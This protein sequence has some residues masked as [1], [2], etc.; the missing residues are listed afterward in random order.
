[1]PEQDLGVINQ[2]EESEHGCTVSQWF[3]L[4]QG[5]QWV[6]GSASGKHA[7]QVVQ[8]EGTLFL[9]E[10]LFAEPTWV[11][12]TSERANTL[13]AYRDGRWEPFVKF[14]RVH[15]GWM[16]GHEACAGFY[17]HPTEDTEPIA[18]PAGV[19][20]DV[21]RVAYEQVSDPLALCAPPAFIEL[22]FANG[23]GVVSIKNGHNEVMPLVSARVGGKYYP[24]E[25]IVEGNV[26]TDAAKY[27][28][29][30]NTIR[31]IREPCPS[32]EKTAV[33]KA[34]FVVKNQGKDAVE[35]EFS[36]GCQF[37][38]RIKNDEGVIVKR[39]ADEMACLQSLTSLRL[40][41]G[42]EKV[43]EARLELRDRDGQ[44]LDGEF[45]LEAQLT[46]MNNDVKVPSAVSKFEVSYP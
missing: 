34:A 8:G 5:N 17:A 40:E 1:L 19:F 44:Q 7:V 6:F 45:G 29:L 11:S 4:E 31:C 32:N 16:M 39:L 21:K 10:G 25:K 33:M 14:N 38:L 15:A 43:Y 13:Y 35:F 18:T 24:A 46:A 26:S 30:P 2:S 28:S 22:G 20:S 27:E 37:D 23:V 42:E 36:S 3:P 41:P 12:S 9:V